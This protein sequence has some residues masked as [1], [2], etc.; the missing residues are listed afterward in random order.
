MFR[1]LFGQK[2]T[3]RSDIA[4]AVTGAFYACFKAY[5]TITRYKAEQKAQQDKENQS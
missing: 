5:D 1:G 3:T 2:P 4:L